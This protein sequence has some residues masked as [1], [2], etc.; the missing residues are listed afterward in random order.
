MEFCSWS[1]SILINVL[2]S[3]TV[4]KRYGGIPVVKVLPANPPPPTHGSQFSIFVLHTPNRDLVDCDLILP[5]RVRGFRETARSR[6][7]AGLRSL[8]RHREATSDLL[9]GFGSPEQQ[10]TFTSADDVPLSRAIL[11]AQPQ[12]HSNMC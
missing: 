6:R 10:V 5:A 12:T 9:P 7:V 4:K 11:R 8:S 3:V 1:L 2:S